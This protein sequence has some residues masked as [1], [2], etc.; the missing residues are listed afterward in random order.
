ML[1]GEACAQL[2][3]L[4]SD[5]IGSAALI[6]V[7]SVT[8]AYCSVPFGSVRTVLRIDLVK[9]KEHDAGMVIQVGTCNVGKLHKA[10]QAHPISSHVALGAQV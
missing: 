8:L 3:M 10:M 1:D 2:N 6:F 7:R 4:C 5:W 9:L